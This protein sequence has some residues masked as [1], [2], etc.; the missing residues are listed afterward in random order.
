MDLTEFKKKVFEEKI[1]N[2]ILFE[3]EADCISTSE[4]INEME[5]YYKIKFP[6]SYRDFLAEYGGGYFAF[7]LVYSIDRNSP[8]Y[9][10]SN[11]NIEFVLKEKF[12][13]IIDLETG[14][15]AGFRINDGVCEDSVVIYNHENKIIKDLNIGL[16]EFILMYGVKNR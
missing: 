5:L 13:P 7:I 4:Q 2:P 8:F 10:P 1:K 15:L 9:L 16:F 3:L 14:D 6:S 12:L 11:V